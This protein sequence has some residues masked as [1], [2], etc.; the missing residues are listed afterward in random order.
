MKSRTTNSNTIPIEAVKVTQVVPDVPLPEVLRK[1]PAQYA[2]E[3]L[4]QLEAAA[5]CNA[6]PGFAGDPRGKV[7][8]EAWKAK[9]MR[10]LV[11]C[12]SERLKDSA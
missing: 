5:E 2:R 8:V 11:P 3:V 7:V 6:L 4:N 1:A 9:V 10:D 12:E